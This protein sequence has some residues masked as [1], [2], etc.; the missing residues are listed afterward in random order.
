M[1]IQEDLLEKAKELAGEKLGIDSSMLGSVTS[2][3]G[4]GSEHKEASAE[5]H[6]ESDQESDD[7]QTGDGSSDSEEQAEERPEE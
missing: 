1:E 5:S 7:E 4:L 6:K 2:M 3:L